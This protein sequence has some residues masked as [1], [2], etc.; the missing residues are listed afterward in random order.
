M[1]DCILLVLLKVFVYHRLQRTSSRKCKAHLGASTTRK[2]DCT[3]NASITI[4][5][6][7]VEVRPPVLH[8]QAFWYTQLYRACLL[9]SDHDFSY[10]SSS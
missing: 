6:F 1:L 7:D 4:V 2:L 5:K 8:G 10:I 3:T 9:I